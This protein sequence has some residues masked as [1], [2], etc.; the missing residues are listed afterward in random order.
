MAKQKLTTMNISMPVATRKWIEKRMKAEGCA[1][2]SE[3]FRRLVSRDQ[4]AVKHLDALLLEG[5]RS[6]KPKP[7][8]DTLV[9]DIS[10]SARTRHL[11]QLIAEGE[12]SGPAKEMTASDWADL[13][14]DIARVARTNR[15]RSDRGIVKR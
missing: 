14:S 10:E 2:A 6:G 11:R 1:N 7:L 4:Q 8:T 5:L 12:Q 15:P 3:Y 9:R 13:H